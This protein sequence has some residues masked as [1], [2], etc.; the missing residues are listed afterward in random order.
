LSIYPSSGGGAIPH[1]QLSAL[2]V[3]G[4]GRYADPWHPFAET[5]VC[6]AAILSD[7]GFTVAVRDDVDESLADLTGVDLL[8]L[9]IG[10]ADAA[11]PADAATRTG[12]LRFVE[13]GGGVMAMHVAATSLAGTPEWEGI[14]GGIWVRGTTMH[15]PLDRSLIRVYADRHVIVAH[16][17]D[18]EIEDERYSNLRV[19]DDVVP[20]VAHEFEGS[21]HPLVWARQ[22][23]RSR[24]VYDA[25][26]HDTRSYESP[27]HRAIVTRAARWL[28]DDL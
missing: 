1:R 10:R 9:N 8:V 24:V 28:T 17:V 3:S 14:L 13:R 15:P 26:G 25:L 6:L 16:L 27:E 11:D 2:V 19:A 7:A 18:F 21:E 4:S 20:L 23:G 22:V 12:L 5:S